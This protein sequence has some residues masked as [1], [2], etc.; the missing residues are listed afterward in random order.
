VQRGFA[1]AVDDPVFW[2]AKIRGPACLN[3]EAAR[4]FLP[5]ITKKA[6][7]VL[8]GL[9]K[10]QITE[11]IKAAISSGEFAAPAAGAMCYMMSKQ[12]Y[13]SDGNPHWHP[14]LM[15]YVATT[16]DASWGANLLGS[17]LLASTDKIEGYTIF[18]LPVSKWSDGTT[19]PPLH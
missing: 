5:H 8:A 14:H 1:A 7:W 4:S 19:G 12:Q 16:D 18:M 10:E 6:Q 3:A 13:V 2:N 17:P 9:S 11:R 15:F